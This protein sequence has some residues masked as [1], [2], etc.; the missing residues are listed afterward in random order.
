MHFLDWYDEYASVS[1]SPVRFPSLFERRHPWSSN[2]NV[3]HHLRHVANLVFV[4]AEDLRIGLTA[5]P[6][7]E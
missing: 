7:P 3:N 1:A 4:E 6:P 5:L 2:D